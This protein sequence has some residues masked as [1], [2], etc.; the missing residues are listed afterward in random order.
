MA[1]PYTVAALVL[2]GW[3]CLAA[4][5][6]SVTAP[7]TSVKV[8]PK[9]AQVD[10]KA[11]GVT[12][13]VKPGANTTVSVKVDPK[14]VNAKPAPAK[15]ATVAVAPA[16]PKKPVAVKAIRPVKVVSSVV[17]VSSTNTTLNVRAPFTNVT[18]DTQKGVVVTAPF[19]KVVHGANGTIITAPFVGA[20]I[21]PAPKV[22]NKP[23]GRRL[24]QTTNVVAPFTNVR[25]APGNVAV[26]TPWAQ[27][28]ATNQ[29]TVVSTPWTG[30]IVANYGRRMLRGSKGG[31][32]Q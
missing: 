11:P 19:T 29:G 2:L 23:T 7:Q 20:I 3:V 17:N 30:P 16:A 13:G 22:N 10:V 28:L 31:Q 5:D 15:T 1:T 32:Q 14:K 9:T 24:S 8:D 27:V 18:V 6:V 4:A 26:A 25:A 12:V 21:V